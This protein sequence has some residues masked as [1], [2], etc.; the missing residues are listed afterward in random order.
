MTFENP[1]IV[2]FRV[3]LTFFHPQLPRVQLNVSA[4]SLSIL[5]TVL[6][7]LTQT[8]SLDED[9]RE[10]ATALVGEY[11]GQS[12]LRP[13]IAEDH[14]REAWQFS[15]INAGA[16]LLSVASA[17]VP[18]RLVLPLCKA[19]PYRF[20]NLDEDPSELK[21]MEFWTMPELLRAVEAREGPVA[22][23]WVGDAE[24]LGLWWASEQK[25]KWK[26]TG[27]S[28]QD[29]KA[30]ERHQGVG[31]LGHDHWWNT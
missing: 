9:D 2:N 10:A 3:P 17:A 19:A 22:A 21:P 13:Y 16:A 23:S 28:R 15:I 27:A 12:F 8:G 26:Y 30:P 14:E 29:D 1:H 7:L 5:P 4:T 18:W 24:K 31:R 20:T 6:D 11:E 25:Q